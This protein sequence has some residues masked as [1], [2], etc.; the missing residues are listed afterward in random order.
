[1]T[2]HQI[3]ITNLITVYKIGFKSIVM[4]HAFKQRVFHFEPDI[5]VHHNVLVLLCVK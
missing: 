1:M 3:S 2:S 4:V 5:A